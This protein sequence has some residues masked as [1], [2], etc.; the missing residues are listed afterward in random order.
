METVKSD[1]SLLEA[2]QKVAPLLNP[3]IQ[4][5]VTVGIY[6]TEKLLI[7]IPGETF[8]LPV[9]QGDPLQEGDIITK[10]I[11][12]GQP[13]TMRVPKEVF[14]VPVIARAIPL[15]N[16]YGEIIG[17]V[18][19]GTSIERAE[20]LSEV[21]NKLY[22]TFENITSVIEEVTSTSDELSRNL[23][24][25]KDQFSYM[26]KNIKSIDE[27]SGDVTKISDQSNILGLN[28][29]IEAA[30]AGEYGKGFSVVA[31]EVRKLANE[32]KKSSEEISDITS[33]LVE[34]VQNFE[35]MVQNVNQQSAEQ[36]DAMESMSQ[37]VQDVLEDVEKLSTLIDDNLKR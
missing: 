27:F 12:E 32:S 17:G 20:V 15:R 4:E 26:N 6:D 14:G 1:L 33:A 37:A 28:A 18:G 3:L 24:E 34:N 31:D 21:S 11:S 9:Q 22:E 16:D 30:R 35:Q 25:T 23:E 8:Q 10:A 2:F 13:Q 29:S 19:I 5:D 36:S 7:N